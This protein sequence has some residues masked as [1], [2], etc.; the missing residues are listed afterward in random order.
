METKELIIA[1]WFLVGFT[2]VLAG[3]TII[4]AITTWKLYRGS[5]NQVKALMKLTE[6]VL[7]LPAIEENVKRQK[8]LQKLR[9]E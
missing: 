4:Y 9:D 5:Q 1:T 7:S 6:A 2:G 8:E 3:A